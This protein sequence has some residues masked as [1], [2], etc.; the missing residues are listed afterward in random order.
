MEF[1]WW[2]IVTLWRVSQV[3]MV[4]ITDLPAEKTRGKKR[5]DPYSFWLGDHLLKVLSCAPSYHSGLP[6]CSERVKWQQKVQP[7]ARMSSLPRQGSCRSSTAAPGP[8]MEKAEQLR[9]WWP[10]Y[11]AL[12]GLLAHT[13]SLCSC[14]HETP[15]TQ[16]M[17]GLWEPATAT[18]RELI[19]QS[20]HWDAC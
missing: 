18:Q 12:P 20:L 16:A 9:L 2:G 4:Y 19:L 14:W 10:H 3:H 1:A 5:K 15:E 6:P 7:G 17:A 8:A 13:P 11:K